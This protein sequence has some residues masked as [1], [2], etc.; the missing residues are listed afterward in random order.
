MTNPIFDDV[1][2]ATSLLMSTAERLPFDMKDSTLIAAGDPLPEYEIF[3][4]E[5]LV[6]VV[7][8]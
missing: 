4:G 7:R 2:E 5:K 3:D 6:E 1:D 8:G